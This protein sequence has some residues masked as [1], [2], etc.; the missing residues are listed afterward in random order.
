MV[1]SH[2]GGNL[3][4]YFTYGYQSLSYLGISNHE[5][6]V[7]RCLNF[8]FLIEHLELPIQNYRNIGRRKWEIG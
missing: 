4:K 6:W 3:G 7:K 2:N 1:K 8:G 5:N